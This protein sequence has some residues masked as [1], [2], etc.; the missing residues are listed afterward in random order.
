MARDARTRYH[1]TSLACGLCTCANHAPCQTERADGPWHRM[2]QNPDRHALDAFS[3]VARC[4][5][6]L[7]HRRQRPATGDRTAGLACD[8]TLA[9]L[10]VSSMTMSSPAKKVQAHLEIQK[11]L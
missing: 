7:F 9:A 3:R 1:L 2:P 11:L 5:H 8:L 6:Q 10:V 4:F